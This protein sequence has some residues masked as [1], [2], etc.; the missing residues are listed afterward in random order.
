MTLLGPEEMSD[1]LSCLNSKKAHFD[2]KQAWLSSPHMFSGGAKEF[3]RKGT[4]ERLARGRWEVFPPG[5]EH[6]ARLSF[7]PL[8]NI[9]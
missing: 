1:A 8:Q 5:A 9:T 7:E 3:W 6:P 4:S 2:R